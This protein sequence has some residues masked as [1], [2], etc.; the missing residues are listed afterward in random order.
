L[1]RFSDPC[2]SAR[3][4]RIWRDAAEFGQQITLAAQKI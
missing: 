1:Q 3:L 4:G 2:S